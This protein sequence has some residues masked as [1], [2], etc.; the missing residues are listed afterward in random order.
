MRSTPPSG[1]L[2][3]YAPFMSETTPCLP[4]ARQWFVCTGVVDMSFQSLC[5]DVCARQQKEAYYKVYLFFHTYANY[6]V[7]KLSCIFH[8]E[9]E[10]Q[11]EVADQGRQIG[12]CAYR[13]FSQAGDFS[14]T[15][16]P[17]GIR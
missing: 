6:V 8:V 10:R 11:A 5:G 1:R 13:T 17:Y 7:S 12:Q 3:S 9:V 2:I 16:V 15:D 4:C 14:D